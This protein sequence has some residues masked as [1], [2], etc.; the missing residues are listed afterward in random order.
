MLEIKVTINCPDLVAAA[1]AFAAVMQSVV[2]RSDKPTTAPD[3]APLTVAP[4]APAPA[5]VAP[6]QAPVNPTAAAPVSAPVAPVTPTTPAPAPAAVPVAP[7]AAPAPVAP[8]SPAP[9]ITLAQ[10]AEA[11]ANLIS[12]DSSKR[13]VLMSLLQQF[14]VQSVLQ[15]KP[16]Q[17][18]AF[19]T[20]MRGLGA[21]I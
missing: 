2:L 1:E 7:T 6:V 10:L 20:A 14:G 15:L 5:P 21:N 8:T 3:T 9:S 12:A 4:V 17:I 16:D 18:G 13:P 11:G 19:A